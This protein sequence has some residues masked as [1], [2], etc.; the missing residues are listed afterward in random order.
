MTT[1]TANSAALATKYKPAPTPLVDMA[2]LP[3]S[4]EPYTLSSEQL[5]SFER[6]GYLILRDLLADANAAAALQ[7]WSQQVHDW[8]AE[9]GSG[10]MPYREKT[11]DGRTVLTR[12]E[13][14][15]PFHPGFR[16]LF[17]GQR[18]TGVL[19][20]LSG[21]EMVLF[22]EKINYKL[23]QAGGF[24]AHQDAP[25]YT[26]AGALKH[27]TINIAV[28]RATP[29]NGCLE[30]VKGS[31]KMHDIPTGADNCIPKEWESRHEWTPVPLEPGEVLIFGSYLAHRSGAK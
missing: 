30:V 5:A 2:A 9:R 13:H 27:L 25:A 22:K 12:T 20:Q 7:T 11:L 8:P 21:E 26:H 19:R 18:L 24:D 1:D 16:A 4:D 23:P 28:H 15:S 17:R 10:W 14:Y 29:Q 6:D 31:H 3:L